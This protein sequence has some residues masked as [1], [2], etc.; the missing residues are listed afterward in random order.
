MLA[1]GLA[2]KPSISLDVSIGT[3]GA[4]DLPALGRECGAAI[5]RALLQA[6]EIEASRVFLVIDGK[7]AQ[8]EGKVRFEL[9]LK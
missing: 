5:E 8:Q 6:G 3:L 4:L 2:Q 7:I 1:R 9:G